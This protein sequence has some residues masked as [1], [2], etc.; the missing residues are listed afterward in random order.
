MT[1]FLSDEQDEP[2]DLGTLRGIAEGALKAEGLPED[3]EVAVMFVTPGQITEYNKRFMDRD[4]AT[5]VLA[6]PVHDLE[7]GVVP[8][9]VANAPP[10]A[11]GDVFL[12]PDE[13]TERARAERIDETAF[14]ELLL[15][16]GILHLLGYDHHDDPSARRMEQ[17]EEQILTSLGR[18]LP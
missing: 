8:R 17:R 18:E 16:H 9:T 11:L 3:T 1:V 14:L 7:P 6:F 15:V 2:L 5:D 12:C 10:L 13:I 4:G